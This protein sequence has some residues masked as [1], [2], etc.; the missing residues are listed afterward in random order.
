ERLELVVSGDEVGLAVHL[1]QDADAAAH[2]DVAADGAL[3]GLASG[4]LGR[5]GRTLGPEQVDRLLHVAARVGQR[6]LALHHAGAG[7][8]PELLYVLSRDR[9]SRVVG[10][11]DLSILRASARLES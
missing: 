3:R 7:A 1:H 8:V 10:M 4:A 11:S 9:H 6:R 2:V 5:L